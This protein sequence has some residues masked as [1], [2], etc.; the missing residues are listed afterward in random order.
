MQRRCNVVHL[1]SALLPL[2]K[3]RKNASTP[4]ECTIST[5]KKDVKMQRQCNLVHLLKALL[6]RT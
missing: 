5:V 1:W 3:G 6:K 4:V 2:L